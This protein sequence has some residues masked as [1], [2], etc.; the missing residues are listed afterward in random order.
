MYK[1][2]NVNLSLQNMKKELPYLCSTY[3]WLNDIDKT[4]LQTSLE[5]LD[6]AFKNYFEKRANYPKFKCKNHKESYRTNCMYDFYYGN[7]YSTIKV[8][9]LNNT[10]KLPKIAPVKIKGSRNRIKVINK[11]NR[12]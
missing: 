4:L 8:D 11:I 7:R 10:I 3:E 5:D 9:L 1:E 12:V 2:H 6:R